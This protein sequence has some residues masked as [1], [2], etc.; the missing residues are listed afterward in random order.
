MMSTIKRMISRKP[1]SRDVVDSLS[2]W[3][4]YPF[5]REPRA[6]KKTYRKIFEQARSASYPEIDAV[7]LEMKH[8]IDRE[9]M[10]NLALHTQVV[11]KESQINY[12]HGR[13]LYATLRNRLDKIDSKEPIKI[14]ETGTARGF[15]SLC[16]AR[17]LSDAN[18][19]GTIITLDVL[20]HH[21]EMYWNCIDDCELPKTRHE[22]LAPWREWQDSIIYLQGDTKELLK[23]LS[24][25]RIHFAFLDAQHTY[26]AV[27]DE[28]SFI[29]DY[30]QKGDI[31]FFDDV[32][33]DLYPG[34]V[35]AVKEVENRSDYEITRIIASGQR[36]YAIATRLF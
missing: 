27:M 29:I 2:R 20:P 11:I 30:H 7:E 14:L 18:R 35:A 15:S 12:Q 6:D 32:T 31:I 8:S 4:N 10:D 26:E 33:P 5:G 24:M 3:N 16:M 36:G 19:Q 25:N 34:V 23:H 1:S 17:A 9:W 21:V 13:L 22:L 28:A